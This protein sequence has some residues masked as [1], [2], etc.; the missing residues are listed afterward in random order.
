MRTELGKIERAEF[1]FGGYQDA[2]LGIGFTLGGEGW[3]VTDFWGAWG[4]EPSEHAKWDRDDQVKELGETCLRVRDLLKAAKVY[5]V[6]Q[7]S[8]KPIQAKFDG[9]LLKEWR[10]LT[11][12]L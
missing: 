8:G 2:Q 7:L 11:E 9:N 1:G 4:T 5:R 6:D 10:I 3:G 12:V